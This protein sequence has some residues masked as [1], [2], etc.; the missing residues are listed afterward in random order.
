MKRK[1][2]ERSGH[3]PHHLYQ[4]RNRPGSIII[5]DRYWQ[6]ITGYDRVIQPVH[7]AGYKTRTDGYTDNVRSRIRWLEDATDILKKYGGHVQYEIEYED[8]GAH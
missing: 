7:D 6:R 5:R 4:Y 3:K 1:L 8:G 2:S